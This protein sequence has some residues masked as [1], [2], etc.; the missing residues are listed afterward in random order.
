MKILSLIIR[1]IFK[2]TSIKE[3]PFF[4]DCEELPLRLK[5]FVLQF[6][7]LYLKFYYVLLDAYYRFWIRGCFELRAFYW[8]VFHGLILLKDDHLLNDT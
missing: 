8:F 7:Y 2:L 6:V 3:T 4:I 1:E 5:Y